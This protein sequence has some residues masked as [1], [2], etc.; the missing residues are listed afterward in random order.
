[1]FP[2]GV[3]RQTEEPPAGSSPQL[4][5]ELISLFVAGTAG[6]VGGGPR[7]WQTHPAIFEYGGPRA[8]L[9]PGW[10]QRADRRSGRIFFVNHNL[11]T[12]C[13]ADP[14]TSSQSGGAAAQAGEGNDSDE[15]GEDGRDG[16]ERCSVDQLE[17]GE[18]G[19]T[20]HAGERGEE[21]AR[22]VDVASHIDFV[23]QTDG[24][25]EGAG[26]AA[27]EGASEEPSE[28]AR[29]PDEDAAA[30]GTQV[31]EGAAEATSS[32]AKVVLAARSRHP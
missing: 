31:S 18:Q 29:E 15:D 6:V 19:M 14:R 2:A 4:D 20:T 21:E 9:P 11:R 23:A 22:R 32:G 5:H 7:L 16:D 12:T 1:M 27:D 3:T 26:E 24:A 8:D 28:A 30:A 17:E 10:E 25:A 13:W